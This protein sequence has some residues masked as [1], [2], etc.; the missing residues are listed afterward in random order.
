M[1]RLNYTFLVH[2]GPLVSVR[3]Q[4]AKIGK[5]QIEKLVP[6]F[7]EGA[8]D[9]DLLNEG[10]QNLRNYFESRGY[11]DVKV[12]H[13]PVQRDAQHLTVLYTVELG[14][15]HVVDAVT[16]SGN[17]YFSTPLI[18]QR[19]SVRASSLLDHDGAFSQ[20][21]VAQDV[22]GIKALYQSNG[23]SAVVVTP[24]FTDSDKSSRQQNKVSHFKIAYSIDEGTQRR[25]GKYDIQG[26]TAGQL[27]DL[28]PLAECPG[29]A[30]LFSGQ[31]QSGSGPDPD[32]LLQQGL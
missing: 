6:V 27:N 12:S 16:V 24:R 26:A 14:K 18:T 19:L 11:F 28:H 7:E 5:D 29:R 3:V 32:L 20:Q 15:R 30:A 22:A 4:G 13:E 23:Y 21:L 31:H 9:L 2:Q 8:V 25:I 1:N 17:K 10:A